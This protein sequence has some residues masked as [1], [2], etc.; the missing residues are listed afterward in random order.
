MKHLYKLCTACL[1]L[2]CL[3]LDQRGFAQAP[4]H[5][6]K[7]T[8]VNSNCGGYWE[9]LPEGY[10]PA[11]SQLYPVLIYLHGDGD[12]GSGSQTDLDLLLRNALPQ[13]IQAGK[14]PNSFTAQ[15]STFK[16]IVISPQYKVKLTPA[17]T[18]S[19]ITYVKN[20]YKI[21]PDR[22]YLTGMSLGGG[23]TWEYAGSSASAAK[24]LAGIIP[25]CGYSQA[26]SY[27]TDNMG[28]ADLP[29][30]AT[31]NDGDPNVSV[32][33]TNLYVSMINGS[34][35]PPTP[36]ARKTIFNVNTH[37]AWTQTYDPSW[38][39]NGKNV[40][41]W[42]LQYTRAEIA[43]PVTLSN[44][45]IVAAGKD[46]VTI[47]WTTSWEHNNQFFS[48][49]RSEDGVHFSRIGQV[50]ATN[51][52]NGS[53]YSFNDAH[54]SV[55]N[56]FYRL[57]QTD[58]NGKTTTYSLLKATIEVQAGKLLLFPNPATDAIT[59]GFNHPNKDR[60]TVRLVNAQG[61]TVQVNQ[62][63]KEAGYWQQRIPTRQLAAGQYFVRVAGTTV[64]LTQT[65]MI[66]K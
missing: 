27:Q 45:K 2:A 33:A 16:F 18:E 15:G 65:V 7:T 5:R 63:N 14:F 17:E 13:Y 29:V 40:Y 9:Y 66:K 60:I 11:S 49:E 34:S 4:T 36:L 28:L 64:D 24:R 47:T 38:E 1:L 12:R 22:I 51:N 42:A 10:N 3:L 41:E 37:D 19:I 50:A 53:N 26:Y 56:N 35:H 57:S 59:I 46:G 48:I 31:H 61:V 43:L 55:G 44:Y 30:W 21:D 25:V 39:E 54:P 62:F 20:N 23:I 6:K 52:V 32:E 8:F 58:L